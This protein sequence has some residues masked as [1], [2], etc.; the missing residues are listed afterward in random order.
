MVLFDNYETRFDYFPLR[1]TAAARVDPDYV[2]V[3]PLA[4]EEPLPEDL[5]GHAILHR[6]SGLAL[7]ERTR[8]GDGPE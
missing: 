7:L 6:A 4:P 2:V 5:R 1:A 8:K 3:W